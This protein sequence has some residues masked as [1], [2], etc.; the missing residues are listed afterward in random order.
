MVYVVDLVNLDKEL[1]VII[2]SAWADKTVSTRKSQWKKYIG[3]CS[4]H[5]L[6]AMPATTL[7]VARFLTYLARSC[8][9]STINNYLSALI[10]LHKYHGFSAEFRGTFYIQLVVRGL[11]RILG[12]EPC[13]AIPLSPEQLLQCYGTISG[14]DSIENASWAAVVLCF[15]TLLRKSNVLP[16]NAK[17]PYPEHIIRR[18]DV[19][20]YAWGMV[21]TIGASKTIQF[22]E[23][24]L[25]IPVFVMGHSP[26][27][28]VT[29]LR[30]HMIKHPGAWNDP[31]FL[32]GN[33]AT[34]FK[35]LLYRDVLD[36]LKG[37]VKKIGL[38]SSNVGLHSLRRSGATFLCRLGIPLS[39]IKCVGD[40]RSLAVLEY[41][42][43]PMS[44]KLEI[45]DK[46]SH[47]LE[48]IQ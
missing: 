27:C 47:A 5:G 19:K 24:K 23:R 2:S 30:T 34:G 33:V 41:L 36:R 37:W 10:V 43:T 28:A 31:L 20:F 1:S 38:D 12:D 21:L 45:E 39:D 18:K 9:F 15:R 42:V 3:F 14:K 32:K 4:S 44:R 8:K 25:E 7:T 6:I 17:P 26:F 48:K 11:K 16:D 13:Q 35:P 29:L 40:W 22:K 46:C